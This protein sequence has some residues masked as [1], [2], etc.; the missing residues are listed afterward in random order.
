[1]DGHFLARLAQ[2][3]KLPPTTLP[4]KTLDRL[5]AFV[6]RSRQLQD[7]LENETYNRLNTPHSRRAALEERIIRLQQELD[8]LSAE[9]QED[10]RARIAPVLAAS[11][12]HGVAR[13]AQRESKWL[14]PFQGMAYLPPQRIR[15]AIFAVLALGTLALAGLYVRQTF[16]PPPVTV[17]RKIDIVGS[18]SGFDQ[19]EIHLKLGQPVT[20]RLTSLNNALPTDG[21]GRHQWAVDELGVNLI[22]PPDGSNTVTFTPEKAGKFAF[23]CDICCGGRANPIMNGTLVVES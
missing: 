11:A 22:A 13:S 21:G 12:N 23:Y 18:M 15:A 4:P 1:M 6:A 8:R 20:V 19:T 14:H 10:F 9:I 16:F 3:A 2:T 7:A 5:S 17:S